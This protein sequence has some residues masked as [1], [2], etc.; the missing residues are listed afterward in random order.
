[1]AEEAQASVA[2][3]IERGL[4]RYGRGELVAAIVEWESALKL[5]PANLR[6]RQYIQY[7][8]ENFELLAD[9]FGRMIQ[10]EGTPPAERR[11]TKPGGFS[12][13]SSAG[14]NQ[15]AAVDALAAGWDLEDFVP[16]ELPPPP[17]AAPE[18]TGIE[19]APPVQE[20]ERAPGSGDAL[21]DDLAA[22]AQAVLDPF[23]LEMTPPQGAHVLEEEE[24]E[25]QTSGSM[26]AL[27]VRPLDADPMQHLEPGLDLERTRPHLSSL[28]P[29]TRAV[30]P[31]SIDEEKTIDRSQMEER[32]IDRGQLEEMTIDRGQA[33]ADARTIERGGVGQRGGDW[34]RGDG[35][36]APV[37]F[38]KPAEPSA[39]DDFSDLV[40]EP[41]EDRAKTQTK[42]RAL[43][44]ESPGRKVTEGPSGELVVEFEAEPPDEFAQSVSSTFEVDLGSLEGHGG[45]SQLEADP[46]TIA[47]RKS[48]PD[49]PTP[50]IDDSLLGTVDMGPPIPLDEGRH[51]SFPELEVVRP[52]EESA[53]D[54]PQVAFDE[55]QAAFEPPV[56]PPTG[57]HPGAARPLELVP[58]E[59]PTAEL[60]R[61]AAPPVAEP[62]A[63][64]REK[65]TT[66]PDLLGAPDVFAVADAPVVAPVLERGAV[67]EHE[68]TP[69]PAPYDPEALE[70]EFDVDASQKGTT[71]IPR[72]PS[73]PETPALEG[74]AGM[75]QAHLLEAKKCFER[76]EIV[77][78]ATAANEAFA[79]DPDGE[80]TAA[81]EA[82]RQLLIRIFET[83]LGSLKRVPQILV[84]P[85][86]ISQLGLDH[87]F[88]FMLSLIDGNTSFDDL[89]DI[90]GMPRI[91]AF[92]ILES[93]LRQGVISA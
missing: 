21:G 39:E 9:K 67:F 63:P 62:A 75:V 46:P 58:P 37:T 50:A 69:L 82:D 88:G 51:P 14:P 81:R 32:T 27:G 10:S 57:E 83:Q 52:S 87:R 53:F 49:L 55:P 45:S 22:V 13:Q 89:L 91:E 86:Q 93:L 3:H 84:S 92:R 79:C 47:R 18:P 28:K 25:P 65:P 5:D 85:S 16:D 31:P 56:E 29:K 73:A 66:P 41:L 90:A 20:W 35:S 34:L 43:I 6:A 17:A 72:Q 11:S 40:D 78:A 4:E 7:V 76:G 15:S 26:E 61:V 38:G 48:A 24:E 64:A 12:Q 77:A 70:D 59:P 19:V 71:P 80:A 54:E 44:G 2:E 68:H 33:E 8:R 23:G 36:V 74:I 42:A 1:M 30:P 60:P